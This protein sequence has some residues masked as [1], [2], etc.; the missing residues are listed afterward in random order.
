MIHLNIDGRELKCEQGRTILEAARENDINIPTLCHD[1][2]VKSSGACG[3]CVVET[4]N[5]PRLSRACATMAADGMIIRTNTPRVRESRKMTL[6]LLLSDH[7]GDCR[8]P[9]MLNCPGH[10]DCQ[11]YVGLIANGQFEEAL[12]LIKD[13]IPLPASIGRI[14]PHPCE[15]EC[16]RKL[17]EEPVSIAHLKRFAADLDL[18]SA[19]PYLPEINPVSGKRAA[20]AGG[21]AG[22]LSAAYYLRRSG[23]EVT[24]FDA[25]DEMGGMLRY[26]IP[27]YRLPKT[28]LNAEIAVI[29][30]LGVKMR[31]NIRVGRDITLASL[32]NRYDAVILAV[33]AWRSAPMGLS[34]EELGN[35]VGGIDYLRAAARNNPVYSGRRVAVVGGGNTAMDACRTAVRLGADEVYTLYRRTREEMPAEES[36]IIEAEQEGVVF[37]YLV[38]PLAFTGEKGVVTQVNLQK[39]ALGEPDA[40]GRRAPVPLPGETEILSV[41]LVIIAIGQVLDPAGL[42]G[43]TLT[44]RK[45]VA[46]DEYTFET[47]L[48]GVFAIGD[49]A[50]KGAGIAIEA[51]GEAKRAALVI[52]GWLNDRYEIKDGLKKP[53]PFT[54]PFVTTEDKTAADFLD[55]PKIARERR[56]ILNPIDRRDNFAEVTYNYTSEQAVKEAARCLECG[57]ADYFECKLAAYAGEYGAGKQKYAGARHNS[58]VD[59]SNPFFYRDSAKCI[60]CGLC[61]R[62]CDEVMGLAALGL[63]KRGFDTLVVPEMGAPIAFSGC[64]S[65]GQCVNI[66]PTGAISEIMSFRKPVPVKEKY[67]HTVCGFCGVGCHIKLASGGGMLTRSLPEGDDG[68]LCVKGRFGFGLLNK[69][70]RL[71]QPLIRKNG[72]LTPVSYEEAFVYTSKKLQSVSAWR[73]VDAIGVSISD[74]YT[75]EEIFVISRYARD[76]LRIN[77][78]FCFG[79]VRSGL[80]DIIGF[81]GSTASFEE[82]E[83][84]D[85]VLVFCRDLINTHGIAA[86]RLKNAKENGAKIILINDTRTQ[87]DEWAD[88]KLNT[89]EQ[90]DILNKLL[91]NTAGIAADYYSAKHAVIMFAQNELSYDAARLLGVL[92]VKAGHID[93]PRSGIIQLKPNNNSQGLSDMGVDT[94]GAAYVNRVENGG[95]CGLFVFGEDIPHV[96]LDKLQFLAV[97]DLFLTETAEKANVVFPC[98]AF[99]ESLGT[100]TN[101]TGNISAV[102]PALPRIL[103]MSNREIVQRLANSGGVRLNYRDEAEI[104]NRIKEAAPSYRMDYRKPEANKLYAPGFL[105]EPYELYAPRENTHTLQRGFTRYLERNELIKGYDNR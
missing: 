47:N 60:L 62:V 1:E 12:K 35:V 43:V 102:R 51:I 61:V 34:G 77:D 27:E 54:D 74:R 91:E 5:S 52:D 48:P 63:Y 44:R 59:L 40:S 105:N 66:C 81:D 103:P 95:F 89:A 4:D 50:N 36:E 58:S 90:P 78:V 97:Q 26:G 87:L 46:A 30:R 28:V 23:H 70:R 10:T 94:D 86:T 24:I 96:N 57:C 84:T 67:V 71:T 3:L 9:C 82:L 83:R 8:A 85:L 6:D 68:L 15:K 42:D 37:K 7:A 29:Q 25:M 18:T 20:I 2:R 72:E 99:S 45:T 73:G 17:V 55:K 21:G 56:E 19:Q 32:R 98:A 38:S 16:R 101:T 100:F 39:M 75:N 11:G 76:V 69:R 79:G 65:C 22:G 64:I 13:I 104:F 49:A 53:L 80:K 14:C 93:K 88:I 31:N 92:A 41:D 33:G